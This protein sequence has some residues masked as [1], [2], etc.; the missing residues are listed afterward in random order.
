MAKVAINGFGRIGR[1]V[2][3]ACLEK[4]M[5]VVAINDPFIDLNYMVY[6]FKYDS[7]HGAFKGDCKAENGMLV[8]NG[9]KIQ[10]FAE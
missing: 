4:G 3:R 9:K 6:M 10:V 8:V 7:T 5:D 2:L 1:I